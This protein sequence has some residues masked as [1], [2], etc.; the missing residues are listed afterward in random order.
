MNDNEILKVINNQNDDAIKWLKKLKNI[1]KS[2]NETI[3]IFLFYYKRC[4]E[5][6]KNKTFSTTEL[7]ESKKIINEVKNFLKKDSFRKACLKSNTNLNSLPIL[8]SE[9]I[10]IITTLENSLQVKEQLAYLE[11]HINKTEIEVLTIIRKVYL[12]YFLQSTF[13]S[14][15]NLT[16][17][18]YDKIQKNKIQNKT[19]IKTI[20]FSALFQ[21]IK[22]FYQITNL[23]DLN[24]TNN[25]FK[26]EE[27]NKINDVISY[28]YLLMNLYVLNVRQAIDF[29]DLLAHI[30]SALIIRYRQNIINNYPSISNNFI[31]SN[32]LESQLNNFLISC[33]SKAPLI[34]N[35][36][37]RYNYSQKHLSFIDETIQEYL[38]SKR[39]KLVESYKRISAS[40]LADN[41][42]MTSFISRLKNIKEFKESL[43]QYEQSQDDENKKIL[44]NTLNEVKNV[45]NKKACFEI[46]SVIK[47]N[48]IIMKLTEYDVVFS[49]YEKLRSNQ[50]LNEEITRML[51]SI[52][53]IINTSNS[54][55]SLYKEKPT[56]IVNFN[57]KSY[58]IEETNGLFFQSGEE[59]FSN[60]LK[61]PTK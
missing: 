2:L 61:N 48:D 16:C 37:K 13:Y 38:S 15:I 5:I 54:K 56:Q 8:T 6:L 59:T 42:D 36:K 23:N 17:I 33:Y 43:K 47:G 7:N 1:D 25:L 12:F 14:S 46:I 10:K 50:I 58:R 26:T 39:N 31:F 52:I 29:P 40:F 3:D 30:L 49:M 55:L 11:K 53:N 57:I 60:Q 45:I 21:N 51:I 19:I 20:L 4:L 34:E 22:K 9:E 28:H 32:D 24:D 41:E 44:N 18:A 27:K 35:N